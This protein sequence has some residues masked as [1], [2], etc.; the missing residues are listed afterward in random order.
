[1]RRHPDQ[2][3]RVQPLRLV[4]PRRLGRVRGSGGGGAHLEPERPRAVAAHERGL[5]RGLRF[6]PRPEGARLRARHR[7][8]RSTR[9]SAGVS[10]PAAP[11]ELPP[12]EVGPRAARIRERFTAAG[13]DALLCTNLTNV[14]W[15]TGFTGSAG[16]VLL[17][18]DEMVL[19]TDGRYGDRAEAE[20][21]AVGAQATVV[22][23]LTQAAQLDSISARL[24]GGGRLGLEA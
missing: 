21:A 2:P 24:A 6:D 1:M 11:G 5:A 17:V 23:G 3:W 8:S 10:T 12:L 18:R 9:G 7:R 15:L 13:I 22:V 20:L 4:D 14:R 19:V 16:R